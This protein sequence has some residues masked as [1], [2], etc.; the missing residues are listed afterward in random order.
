VNGDVS[1]WSVFVTE[2]K[3]T[4]KHNTGLALGADDSTIE[5]PLVEAG[6]FLVVGCHDDGNWRV[7]FAAGS[8]LEYGERN[9]VRIRLDDNSPTL[10]TWGT[11]SEVGNTAMH[12]LNAVKTIEGLAHAKKVLIEFKPALSK[13]TAVATF[14][15]VGLRDHLK[16]IGSGCPALSN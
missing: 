16:E 8:T 2:D 13:T 4:G 3:V 15:V 11:S 9:N 1:G 10:E 6:A 14:R 5:A 7:A 12:S